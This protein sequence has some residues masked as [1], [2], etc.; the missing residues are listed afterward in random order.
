MV[1]STKWDRY[2]L[3]TPTTG[4]QGS[5]WF[6]RA[7]SENGRTPAQSEGKHVGALMASVTTSTRREQGRLCKCSS[8]LPFQR[9]NL[10]VEPSPSCLQY[11]LT[12]SYFGFSFLLASFPAA[13]F[14]L[15]GITPQINYVHSTSCL[16]Y[17]SGGIKTKALVISV[18]SRSRFICK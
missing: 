6:S 16:G 8:V 9:R 13:S 18:I 2:K 5:P 1:R 12:H 10:G 3:M 14:L 11:Q 15:L 17:T 7:F 4:I